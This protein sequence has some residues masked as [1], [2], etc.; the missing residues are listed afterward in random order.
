MTVQ[1]RMNADELIRRAARPVG[2]VA[3]GGIAR[4]TEILTARGAVPVETLRPGDRVI[5]REDGM[6]PIRAIAPMD[7]PLYRVAP[8]SLG[9]ARPE[10]ETRVAADQHLVLRDWRA[11]ALFGSDRAL[12]PATRLRDDRQIAPA[13]HGEVYRLDLGRP[14]T[15][16][17]NGLELPTGRTEAGIVDGDDA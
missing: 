4:G 15:I 1:L 11:A 5:T 7:A 17:A 3:R 13:G 16:W 10:R 6:R 14:A 9:L 8:D 12:V 2:A